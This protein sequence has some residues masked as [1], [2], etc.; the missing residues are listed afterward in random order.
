MAFRGKLAVK[1]RGGIFLGG[2]LGGRWIFNLTSL[3]VGG[4]KDTL[5]FKTM[6]GLK[7]KHNKLPLRKMQCIFFDG[8]FFFGWGH[9]G[10]LYVAP[11]CTFLVN[12]K[13]MT[14]HCYVGL[15]ECINIKQT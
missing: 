10:P 4:T 12:F 2:W 7:I 11:F 9:H 5:S 8:V 3:G 6:G 13:W 1:L 15:P 14:F